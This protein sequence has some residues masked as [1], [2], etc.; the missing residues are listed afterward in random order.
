MKTKTRQSK[1]F[2]AP[3]E[4]GQVWQVGDSH[5][6]IGLVGKTLVHYKHYKGL[7]K[8]SPVFLSS[9]EAL[10]KLLEE[11]KAVLL[12]APPRQ[13]PTAAPGRRAPIER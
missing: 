2:L 1:T 4:S 11:Q 7:V 13:P 5:L 12:Q 3:L 9:K 8:A 6:R 10:E